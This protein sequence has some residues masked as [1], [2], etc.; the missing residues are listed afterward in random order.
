MPASPARSIAPCLRF[1]DEDLYLLP[2]RAAWWP[3]TRTLLLADVHLGKPAS[4]RAMGVP[5]PEATTRA[6]L[7][8][9]DILIELLAPDRLIVLGDLLHARAGRAPDTLREF[10]RWRAARPALDL[11]LVRGNHDHAA[12]DPPQEWNIRCLDAPA[13]EQPFVL[14]HEPAED[15][16]GPVICG[17]LHPA[18]RLLG[19]GGASLHAPC[20]WATPRCL[21]LPA[22]GSFTGARVVRAREGDRLFAVGEREVIEAATCSM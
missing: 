12:G 1:A 13:V 22:F 19:P 5:V 4:F 16:R 7:A 10:A 11:L 20:F 18:V 14:A 21:V 15:P 3:R 9:L 17:H 6:D 2:E 8:R